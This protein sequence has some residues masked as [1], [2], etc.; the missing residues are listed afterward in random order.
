M[1]KRLALIPAIALGA[2]GL[3]LTGPNADASH[4][5]I[6]RE[7]VHK[8]HKIEDIARELKLEFRKHYVHL[9]TYRHLMTDLNQICAEAE[10]IDRLAHNPRGQVNHLLADVKELD[11]LAH[12][13]HEVVDASERSARGHIHGNTG[14][15]HE[16]LDV[17]NNTIHR[18]EDTV[19]S[20]RRPAPACTTPVRGYGNS[21]RGAVTVNRYAKPVPRHSGGHFSGSHSRIAWHR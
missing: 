9:E 10:H 4:P 18:L 20:I 2:L 15:V 19:A 6:T 11:Q 7:L 1:K 16:L 17:L 21:H 13:L 14:H 8:A 3:S 12:H 5:T